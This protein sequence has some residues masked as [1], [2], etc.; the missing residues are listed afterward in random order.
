MAPQLRFLLVLPLRWMVRVAVSGPALPRGSSGMETLC[1]L[2]AAST[3]VWVKISN[4]LLGSSSCACKPFCASY[5]L[6]FNFMH[7]EPTSG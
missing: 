7:T 2:P 6:T 1:R 5:R 4:V 3:P